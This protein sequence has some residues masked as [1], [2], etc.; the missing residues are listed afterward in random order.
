MGKRY[1]IVRMKS[2]MILKVITMK[3]FLKY[4]FS[5]KYNTFIDKFNEFE[6][7]QEKK[8]EGAIGTEQ[9]KIIKIRKRIKKSYRKNIFYFFRV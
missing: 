8:N 9:K 2:I 4:D 6:K 3:Q 1:D 7:I 5:R